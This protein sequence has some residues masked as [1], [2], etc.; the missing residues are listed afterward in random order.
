MLVFRLRSS[1]DFLQ[2][3]CEFAVAMPAQETTMARDDVLQSLTERR[4]QIF[5]FARA[6]R[7][8]TGTISR[9]RKSFST[10]R[11]RRRARLASASTSMPNH[12]SLKVMTLTATGSGGLAWSH[13][14]ESKPSRSSAISKELSRISPT[15]S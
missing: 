7:V 11:W 2:H 9:R 3:L 6:T 13:A 1:L 8:S 15:G 14:A 5:A 10:Q 4:A 12:N